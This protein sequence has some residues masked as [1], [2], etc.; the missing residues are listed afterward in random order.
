MERVA[1]LAGDA[2]SAARQHNGVIGAAA[3]AL[4]SARPYA[5]SWQDGSR[6]AN[7][8]A[9]ADHHRWAID[10]SIFVRVPDYPP[11]RGPYPPDEPALLER[12][13]CD[14]LYIGGHYYADRPVP[15]LLMA[16]VYQAW[17]WC[18]GP[19]A[20]SDRTAFASH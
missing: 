3:L 10:D 17:K 8:E 6:L 1:N 19:T 9:L 7:V 20:P 12:G 14:K 18:G 13:T 15:A 4:V 11:G 2:G 16:A 5:G